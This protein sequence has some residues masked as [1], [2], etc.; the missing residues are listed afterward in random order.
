M[1]SFFFE[2]EEMLW[3]AG[4]GSNT[5]RVFK[6]KY[7]YNAYTAHTNTKTFLNRVF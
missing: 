1:S 5:L 2:N 3:V 4:L 6:Y 7:S